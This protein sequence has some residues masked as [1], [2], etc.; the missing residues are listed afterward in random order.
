M[1]D[2][3][4]RNATKYSRLSLGVAFVGLERPARSFDI[5]VSACLQYLGHR[6]PCRDVIAG[7]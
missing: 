5:A 2:S 4:N 6:L 7:V 3:P 1:L